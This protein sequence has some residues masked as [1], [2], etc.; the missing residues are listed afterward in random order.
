MAPTVGDF[1]LRG[2]DPGDPACT[3]T[4]YKRSVPLS[5]G[6]ASD[7]FAQGTLPNAGAG[8]EAVALDRES[9]VADQ[10]ERQVNPSTGWS[11]IPFGATSVCPRRKSKKATPVTSGQDRASRCAQLRK[12]GSVVQT[13]S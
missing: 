5:G 2:Q 6:L 12:R 3:A 8:D 13:G 1:G 9:D 7:P 10:P 11:S 4:S